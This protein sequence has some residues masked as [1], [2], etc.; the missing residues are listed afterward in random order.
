M[1]LK[2]EHVEWLS[3]VR[4][5]SD[6]A[7]NQAKGLEAQRGKYLHYPRCSRVDAEPYCG[8]PSSGYFEQGLREAV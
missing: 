6:L 4:Y 8:G 7:E 2:R 3:I 1:E 5:Q